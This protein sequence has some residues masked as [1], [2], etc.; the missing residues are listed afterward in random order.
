MRM[1]SRPNIE[2]HDKI[3][4]E[5]VEEGWV[6]RYGSENKVQFEVRVI[7]SSHNSSPQ[8]IGRSPVWALLQ[9]QKDESHF[10]AGSL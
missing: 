8:E 2:A 5:S 3:K 6:V 1:P 4:L 9:D 10:N 7:S